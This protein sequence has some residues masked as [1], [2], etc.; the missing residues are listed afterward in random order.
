MWLQRSLTQSDKSD[1][2]ALGE[3][4]AKVCCMVERLLL[5]DGIDTLPNLSKTKECIAQCTSENPQRR[6]HITFLAQ[7]FKDILQTT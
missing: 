1:I 4:L 2:Y 5:K 3:M 6:P 7:I